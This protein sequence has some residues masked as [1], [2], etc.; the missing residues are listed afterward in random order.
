MDRLPAEETAAQL[1]GIVHRDTQLS[2]YGVDLT[3]EAVF[4][5]TSPG[6]LDFGGSEEEVADRSELA[7][8]LENPDDDYGWWKLP[9]GT[10]LIRYNERYAPKVRGVAH[11][12]PHP[13]LMQAGA[14]HPSFEPD[15]EG[16]LETLL[17]VGD[18]G[19]HLKEN[20]RVSKITVVAPP[21]KT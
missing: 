10:Y 21:Q 20:C 9:S 4:K 8:E 3:V 15:S 5:L 18:N 14:H 13:R 2:N 19:I 1:D 17:M 16:T 12:T 11:V 6:A 7:P